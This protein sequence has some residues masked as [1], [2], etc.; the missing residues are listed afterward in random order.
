MRPALE[1]ASTG[2]YNFHL[3]PE[4]ASLAVALT[5]DLHWG[6][7][8]DGDAATRALVA[9]LCDSPPDLLILAGDIGAGEDFE[10]CLALFDNLKCRKALVPGNHD[11]WV[12]DADERGDSW[13]VYSEYL[14][15]VSAEHGFHYLDRGPLLIPEAD[16]A[17]VGSMNWYDYSWADDPRWQPP[18]D[19]KDRLKE[20]VFTRGRHNDARFVRWR[21]TDAGF[22]TKVVAEFE[23]HLTAALQSVGRAI[24]VTHHPAFEGLKYPEVLP[25]HLDQMLWRAF[26][27]NRS[28]ERVLQQHAERIALVFSAHTHNTRENSFAGI[29]GYNI[30]G[31]YGWKR[32]LRLT[33]PA[34]ETSAREFR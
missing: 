31:D 22:T 17:I 27:G 9:D 23:K 11:I 33:W 3:M 26:S 29:H 30:G 20:K 14:P 2:S 5:A 16:L 8:N 10:H 13:R 25:A 34:C 18:E 28:L 1:L 4:P 15:R 19:W 12:R 32:L 6:I 21:F 7:H 24:V